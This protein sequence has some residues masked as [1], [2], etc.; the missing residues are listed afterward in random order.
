MSSQ[1]GRDEAA[2]RFGDQT[3]T[4]RRQ[5]VDNQRNPTYPPDWT[6]TE[7]GRRAGAGLRNV[8]AGGAPADGPPL[9][10]RQRGLAEAR[11]RFGD[12]SGN[13]PS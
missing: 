8:P 5:A 9:T 7:A 10:G 2:R 6:A 12:R 13:Q 3:A 1:R 4:A 11:R